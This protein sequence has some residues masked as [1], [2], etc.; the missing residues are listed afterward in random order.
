MNRKLVVWGIVSC[1]LVSVQGSS[2][3]VSQEVIAFGGGSGKTDKILIDWTL[4]ENA[5]ETF[6]G[7]T[8][9]YTQGFQQPSL[10][11]APAPTPHSLTPAL[12]ISVAPNPVV[13][14]LTANVRMAGNGK[15]ELQLMDMTGKM[16]QHTSSVA[17]FRPVVF[18]MREYATGTYFL[19]V[20]DNTG[21]LLKAFKI[22]K[23]N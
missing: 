23:T 13:S 15:I 2:Q 10:R 19:N 12:E 5:V 4:G 16:L 20:S 22:V 18:N 1:C 3:S 21:K 8:S 6:R 17:D 11:I 14:S 7:P 9:V